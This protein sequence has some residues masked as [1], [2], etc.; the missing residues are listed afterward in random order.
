M[1]NYHVAEAFKIIQR[2]KDSDVFKNLSGDE[3]KIMRKRIIDCVIATDM[4]LHT[5]TL[6]FLPSFIES[7][8]T[9]GKEFDFKEIHQNQSSTSLAFQN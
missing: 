1:E 2:D 6:Q 3:R 5:Q 8:K 9:E 7:N 4:S